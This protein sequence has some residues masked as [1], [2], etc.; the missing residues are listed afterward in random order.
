M[1][2]KNH[3][4]TKQ[5]STIHVQN[6]RNFTA[7][8]YNIDRKTIAGSAFVV[9]KKESL[10]V[11]CKHVVNFANGR[12]PFE[13]LHGSLK[14]WLRF[15]LLP[16]DDEEGKFRLAHVARYLEG[17][18]DDIAVLK[19]DV[20]HLPLHIEAAHIAVATKSTNHRFGS[21]GMRGLAGSNGWP[22]SGHII[23]HGTNPDG[24]PYLHDPLLVRSEEIDRGMSGAAV[25]DLDRRF[26]V[27]IIKGRVVK[28]MAESQFLESDRHSNFAVDC[29]VLRVAPLNLE[30]SDEDE[31]NSYHRPFSRSKVNIRIPRRRALSYLKPN[32]DHAP[33]PIVEEWVGREELIEGINSD[34]ADPKYRVTEL[35]GFGGEGKTSLA[36]Y[37]IHRLLKDRIKPEP[38]GIF[39]WS[40]DEENDAGA[41]FESVLAYMY[42]EPIGRIKQFS[43]T[44]AKA[45]TVVKLLEQIKPGRFIFI[46]DAVE[47][48]QHQKGDNY[49]LI[50]SQSLREFIKYFME[51]EHNSFCIITSRVP[52]ID[53]RDYSSYKYRNVSQLS[54][55]EAISLLRK[56]GVK[57][58]RRELNEIVNK[59]GCHAL[60]VRL[61]GSYIMQSG[62]NV[63]SIRR[64]LGPSHHDDHYK[65]I[66]IL[67]QHYDEILTDAEKT[68]L[69]IFS[70]FRGP[71]KKEAIDKIFRTE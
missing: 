23:G 44:S 66:R 67:L 43:S 30:V 19:L 54:E 68:F 27:G 50:A 26:V 17:H 59:W 10:V 28:D 63:I 47:K 46:L 3:R 7:A 34:W 69:M 21:F 41:F 52:I 62:G 25:L 15:P 14:V 35:I 18:E 38:Y 64:K 2:K 22:A 24:V 65:R 9:D 60:T 12:E 4:L 53:L 56:V 51:I 39:W 37:W 58:P 5:P 33:E 8:V 31:N 36:R 6:P 20:A 13:P 32:L 48:K 61:L 29:S 16:E 71:V 55:N 40:F 1:P 42:N 49:G 70:S 45:Q 57:G 11:T